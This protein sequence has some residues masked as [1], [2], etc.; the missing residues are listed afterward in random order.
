VLSRISEALSWSRK[1]GM[2]KVDIAFLRTKNSACKIRTTLRGPD[3]DAP[4][5]SIMMPQGLS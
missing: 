5:V 4:I 3:Q 2:K 1:G